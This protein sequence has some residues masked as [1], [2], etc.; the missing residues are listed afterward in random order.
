MTVTIFTKEAELLDSP[1]HISNNKIIGET[2]IL[3]KKLNILV[4]SAITK[5]KTN[6][7]KDFRYK[8]YVVKERIYELS[9]KNSLKYKPYGCIKIFYKKNFIFSIRRLDSFQKDKYKFIG[10]RL[11]QVA[12]ELSYLKGTYGQ[13]ELYAESQSLGFYYKL[14]LKTQIHETNKL[15]KKELILAEAEKRI[16]NTQHLESQ[17]MILTELEGKKKIEEIMRSP[18]LFTFA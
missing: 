14:G 17:E 6:K 15:I 8:N 1:I 10:S 11:M 7:N 5:L 2:K 3:N 13:I 9:K 18:I 12:I 16:P 4:D